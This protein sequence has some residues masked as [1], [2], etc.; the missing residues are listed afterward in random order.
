MNIKLPHRF[1]LK[2][3]ELIP[4]KYLEQGSASLAGPLPVFVDKVLLEHGHTPS[5]MHCQW[6]LKGRV[7]YL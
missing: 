6:L 5:F 2:I 3:S 4:L 7:E 1:V